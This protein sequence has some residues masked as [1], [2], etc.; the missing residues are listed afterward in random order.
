MSARETEQPAVVVG[1]LDATLRVLKCMKAVAAEDRPAILPALSWISMW[2]RAVRS[3]AAADDCADVP[4]VA[5]PAFD[6]SAWLDLLAVG[7]EAEADLLEEK[8][9]HDPYRE[10]PTNLS[11]EEGERIRIEA[12]RL[13][14]CANELRQWLVGLA[15]KSNKQLCDAEHMPAQSK[16]PE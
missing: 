15:S 10:R 6:C 9:A 11:V 2:A 3:V 4:T 7:W 5:R 14:L 13:R 12:N 16:S 1:D 8:L